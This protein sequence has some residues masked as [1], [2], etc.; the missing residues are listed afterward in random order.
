MQGEQVQQEQI[1]IQEPEAEISA[2]EGLELQQA[3]G[4][5]QRRSGR[6]RKE[7]C[8]YGEIAPEQGNQYQLSP[9][10]RGRVKSLAARK[11]PKE[12]WRIKKKGAKEL[13][14][15]FQKKRMQGSESD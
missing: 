13:S 9:R 8:R 7:P 11:V 3:A 10:E 2:E 12:D 15:V 4:A 1:R 5:P 14:I 6:S